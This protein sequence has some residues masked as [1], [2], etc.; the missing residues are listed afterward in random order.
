[1]EEARI[2][3]SWCICVDPTALMGFDA[4]LEELRVTCQRC[5]SGQRGEGRKTADR[6]VRGACVERKVKRF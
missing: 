4:A 1:M 5:R 2:G 3:R 6:S